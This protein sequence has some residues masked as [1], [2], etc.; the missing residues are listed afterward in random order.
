MP[1]KPNYVKEAAKEPYN[2]WGLVLF[3]AAAV[4]AATGGAGALL[5]HFAWIFLAAGAGAE[6]LYLMTLPS[7]AAYRRLI[8]YRARQKQL[9]DRK[10]KREALIRTFDPRE[11]NAVDYL[12]WMRKQ[13]YENYQKFTRGSILPD[14]VQTLDIFWESYVDMLD[15]YRRLKNHLRSTNL[16]QIRNQIQQTERSI[17]TAPDDTTRRL[18]EQN[19]EFLQRRM[20][21]FT[22]VE[23]S[24]K[25]VEAQLQSIESFFQL[26]NDEVMTMQSPEQI[27]SLDF[28]SLLSSIELTKEILEQTAPVLTQLDA[29][30]RSASATPTRPPL[31]QRQ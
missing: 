5:Q 7:T 11:R 29:A 31:A 20:S 27:A 4:Y 6:A 26:V 22:N 3:I 17:A 19:L 24:I 18:F 10:H 13:I 8:D 28:D 25:R 1:E 15:T 14:R 9:E 23:T 16:T 2:I 21:N 12:S 30:E